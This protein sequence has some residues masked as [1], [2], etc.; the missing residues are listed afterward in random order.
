MERVRDL[1]ILAGFA[2][3][4]VALGLFH[5][6][7]EVDVENVAMSSDRSP[8]AATEALRDARF[9][10]ASTLILMAEPVLNPI[11]AW[12][13]HGE[14]PGPWTLAAG[15]LILGASLASARRRRR[16]ARVIAPAD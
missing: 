11:W 5:P 7:L 9:P 1:S 12:T 10:R 16:P 4:T 6:H 13:F 3:L 8:E 14:R 2:A 15:V